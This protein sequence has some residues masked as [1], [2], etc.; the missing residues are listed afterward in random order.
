MINYRGALNVKKHSIVKNTIIYTIRILAS[1]LFPLITFPYISRVLS[2]EGIGKY[3]FSNSV[4]SYFSLLAALGISTYA[5]REG[6]KIRKNQKELERFAQEMFSINILSTIAAYIFFAIILFSVPRFNDYRL[7]LFILSISIPLSTLGTEW[8]FNIFEDYIYITVR[9]IVFQF[10]SL[11]LMFVMVKSPDDVNRYALITVI[12]SAGS[13]I[14]N[15]KYASKYFKHKIVLSK[16]MLAY[17]PSIIILFASTIASQIYINSDTTML[18]FF[19][20]DYAVG[21]YSSATKIYNILRSL[22]A[23]FI[24]VLTPRMTFYFAT[25][26]H[27]NRYETLLKTSFNGYVAIVVPLGIGSACVASYM[28]KLLSGEEYLSA[29]SALQILAIALVFSTLGSFVANEVLI[30]TGQE[31]QILFATAFGAV[32]NFVGNLIL[33]PLMSYVGAALTTLISE[34][35]V[36]WIQVYCSKKYFLLKKYMSSFFKSLLASLSIIFVSYSIKNILIWDALK[37]LIIVSCSAICYAIIMFLL[38]H[39]TVKLFMEY[40]RKRRT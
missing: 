19:K 1:L 3:N 25:R 34:I 10:I 40:F 7:I 30:I 16:N 28:I 13:N 35:L 15:Y 32:I 22:L 21:L 12:S 14:L 23:A 26:K 31:K 5:I 4:I 38:Q 17:L 11:V 8:I 24:T 33:I 9:S 2:P 18:G 29:T 27:D 6:A 20:N 39:E 37:V 36:F